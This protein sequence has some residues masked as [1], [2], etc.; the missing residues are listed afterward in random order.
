MS[1]ILTDGLI[2]MIIGM[3]VVFSFLLVLVLAMHGMHHFLDWFNKFMPE[4]VDVIK[5]QKPKNNNE[6]DDALVAVAIA[7]C[8][9]KL[10]K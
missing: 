6:N 8:A 1:N 10:A 5:Q 4:P 2:I 9:N 7:V 3:G